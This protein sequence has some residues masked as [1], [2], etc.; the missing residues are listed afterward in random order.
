MENFTLAGLTTGEVR[1]KLKK[2]GENSLPEDKRFKTVSIFLSQFPTFFNAVLLAAGTLAYVIGDV[3]DAILIFAILVLNT[4][5]AFVQEYRAEKALEKLKELTS[6]NA[7]VIRDGEEK[8]I[9]ASLL[10]PDDI[11]LLSS[12]DKIPAD[13]II[14]RA[15]RLEV[16]ESVLTGE[17]IPVLKKDS[18]MLFSGTLVSKGKA[19][20]KVEKTGQETKFGKIAKNLSG[21]TAD[22]TPLEKRL[23]ELGK[24]I[25]LIILAL[26]ILLVPLGLYRGMDIYSITLLAV[27][28]AVAAIPVSIPAIVTIALALGVSRMAKKK[29]IVRKMPAVETLGSVQLIITDKTGTLTE[30]RMRVKESWIKSE[31]LKDDIILSCVLNNSA[32][33][34]RKADGNLDISGDKTDGA[35]LLWA[36]GEE[37]RYKELQKNSSVIEEYLYDVETKTI[38]TVTEDRGKLKV[39]IR[40]APDEIIEMC[41]D[42][43]KKQVL[44]RIERMAEEGLRVIG[45]ASKNTT[46]KASAKKGYEHDLEFLGLL[47]IYDPPRDEAES[48]IRKAREAGVRTIMVTGDNEITALAIAKEIRL[49]EKD[50]SVITGDA[51]SKMTDSELD[52]IILKSHVFARVQPDQKFKIVEAAK[53]NGLVVGVTG[54]G[55][56]DTLALKRADVGIA[57]G[58]TGTDVAKEAADIVLSNDN[59]S[60]IISAIEEG[61]KIYDN[62]LKTITYLLSSNLS[63]ITFIFLAFILGLPL[64]LLPTQILWI[65]LVTDGLPALA[66]ANDKSD[67]DVLK[68]GPRSNS[69]PLFSKER[70]SFIFGVG[71]LLA[72]M[73]IVVFQIMLNFGTETFART[74]VFNLLVFS[75]LM[76][77]FVV[78]GRLLFRGN[79][80]LVLT[81][82][83]T[84]ALQIIISFTP[85]FQNLFKIGF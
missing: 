35:V 14:I 32:S 59:Y 60:T 58:E 37:K 62:I 68:R 78:R 19:Y 45:F 46:K 22:K 6:P 7:R 55:I 36:A 61:R 63:E 20:M 13:G 4:V 11:V 43:N 8:E 15:N 73:F 85:F 71:L 48:A 28:V 16:D 52:Q 83:F 77:A 84:L 34:V 3:K 44:D 24:Y 74:V 12:G 57:M 75:H 39:L 70:L 18:D 64:P 27:S 23:S 10:V 31:K 72:L 17:S 66:L 65:N 1:E 30:N 54:D 53:R 38:T 50:E 79:I 25:T 67:P 80:Y 69:A 42:E 47:G 29:A 21:I 40:G 49:I 5:L 26:C 33:L 41:K 9:E 76:L 56:N 81:V 82:L 51:I 2:F